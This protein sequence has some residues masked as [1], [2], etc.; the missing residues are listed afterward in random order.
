MKMIGKTKLLLFALL[1]VAS[2]PVSA[3][4]ETANQTTILDATWT[5]VPQS[6]AQSDGDLH[7][8]GQST[9]NY[10][11]Q[12]K[13]NSRYDYSYLTT[14]E[15]RSKTGVV[16][17]KNY[18]K[19]SRSWG[20]TTW[21]ISTNNIDYT[22]L[23]TGSTVSSSLSIPNGETGD[24][25]YM[26]ISNSTGGV[27]TEVILTVLTSTTTRYN[28]YDHLP[29]FGTDTSTPATS[30]RIKDH[31]SI[32]DV[33]VH[34]TIMGN[35]TW[36]TLCLPFDMTDTQIKKSLGTDVIYSEF[37]NV[38][39]DRGYINFYST[40][41]GMKAG[42][43]YLIQNNGETIENFFADDV[44]FTV[45]GVQAANSNR[46][47]VKESHGY[48]FVGLLEP[49]NV[50]ETES[51]Y[52]PNGMA[53]YIANPE[54]GTQKLKRLSATGNIKAFRAYLVFPQ[55][56]TAGAKSAGDMMIDIDDTLNTPTAISAIRVDGQQVSNS[57]YN[58]K[59]QYVGTD[60]SSL[61]KGVYIRNGKKFI[62]R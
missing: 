39:L 42:K 41:K 32:I 14:V 57:I 33:Y 40:T 21:R 60:V 16:K 6:T 17:K 55:E 38:D 19:V 5:E 1:L 9:V 53:V 43:P 8:S 2:Y 61:S 13:T 50:N 35:G 59:G 34:R 23:G 26:T 52:N 24:Y 46:K 25:L 49:T 27:T 47:S 31:T 37:D 36:G 45:A 12:D 15:I 18:Y 58:L 7:L 51:I 56:G 44:T 4:V 28:L 22:S 3:Q 29:L 30:N 11:I 48:Y 20:T 54:N 10:T 62:V